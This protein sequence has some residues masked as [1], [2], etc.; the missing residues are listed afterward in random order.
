MGGAKRE[1]EKA[2]EKTAEG[3]NE[4]PSLITKNKIAMN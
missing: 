4:L 2:S 1:K 3:L